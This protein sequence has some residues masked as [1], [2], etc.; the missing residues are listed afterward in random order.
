LFGWGH[1]ERI[2]D[3]AMPKRMIKGNCIPKEDKED[4][5]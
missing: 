1:V 5:G 3:N 2:E 4:P